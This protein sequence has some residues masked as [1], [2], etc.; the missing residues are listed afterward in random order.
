MGQHFINDKN[1]KIYIV[2]L[3]NNEQNINLDN[4]LIKFCHFLI[5]NLMAQRYCKG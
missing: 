4:F 2:K 1:L 5:S 3:K